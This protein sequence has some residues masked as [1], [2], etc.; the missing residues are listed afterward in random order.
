MTRCRCCTDREPGDGHCCPIEVIGIRMTPA[1]VCR[2][3]HGEPDGAGGFP[4]VASVV[5][6]RHAAHARKHHC[7]R[8]RTWMR[9]FGKNMVNTVILGAFA[10]HTKL[11]SLDSLKKAVAEK[12]A[13]KGAAI[14]EKNIQAITEDYERAE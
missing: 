13:D 5:P 7:N 6:C 10:K 8:P 2:R 12:F 1:R 4:T 9:I 14:I 3:T 11:V